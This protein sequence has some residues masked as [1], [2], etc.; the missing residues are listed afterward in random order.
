MN[1]IYGTSAFMG[2]IMVVTLVFAIIGLAFYVILSL[3]LMTLARKKGIENPWLAWIPFANLYILGKIV[4][5][6]DVSTYNI[7]K[8]E[9]VLPLAVVASTILC[10]IPLIGQIIFLAAFL[11]GVFVFIKLYKMYSPENMALYTVLSCIG[12]F[13]I[14]IF[15]I[16]DKNPVEVPPVGKSIF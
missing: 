1:D 11:L 9:L 6:V 5:N 10:A 7:N 16:K 8:L 14:I 13:S 15:M 3:G 12:L 4:D 2:V